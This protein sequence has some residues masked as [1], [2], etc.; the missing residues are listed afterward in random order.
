MNITI[1]KASIKNS[2]FLAYEYDQSVNSTKNIIKTSSDAP[3]HDD[4][5]DAFH[6]LTPHFAL[7]CEE[8]DEKTAQE[9]IE[10]PDEVLEEENP[11]L[12]YKVSGFSIGGYADNEGATI[13]GSKRLENGRVVNFNTP[14]LKFEDSHEYQF[15]EELVSAINHLKS[16]VYEYLEGK[17]APSKQLEIFVSIDEESSI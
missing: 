2:M 4:L 10:N 7:I 17:Q 11:L 5:R 14:F 8:I 9:A 15:M 13:S 1:K 3:I 6:S 16:E 12:K